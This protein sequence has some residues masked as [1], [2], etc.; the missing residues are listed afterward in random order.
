M[1]ELTLQKFKLAL[2]S[3]KDFLT[4][5]EQQEIYA[6]VSQKVEAKEMTKVEAEAELERLIVEEFKS[7]PEQFT[8][9]ELKSFYEAYE[10]NIDKFDFSYI[11]FRIFKF[12]AY[13]K[14]FFYSFHKV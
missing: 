12:R 13:P 10:E 6:I 14:A 7:L 9:D 3:L 8:L 5:L 4:N 1:K 2:N 11:S